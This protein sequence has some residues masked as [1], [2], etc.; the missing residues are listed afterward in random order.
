M[1]ES[2][3]RKVNVRA[4][5]VFTLGVSFLFYK[6]LVEVSPSVMTGKLMHFFHIDAVALGNIAASYY[7]IYFIMQLPMGILLDRFG[8]RRVMTISIFLCALG[9]LVFAYS[10]TFLM[11]CGGRFLTGLGA[12]VAAIGTLKLIT[13]WFNRK[14]FAFMTGL[15]MSIGMLGAV[16]GE[17]PLSVAID[18]FNW[19]QTLIFLACI[20]FVLMI[21]FWLVVKDRAPLRKLIDNIKRPPL[22]QS[23]K[24]VL[25]KPQTWWL[26][27]YS[28]LAFAPITAF[29][30]LWGV[31]FLEKAYKLS[32][33]QAAFSASL[34]FIGFAIGAPIFGYL[35]EKHGKRKPL[36]SL[37]TVLAF[38]FLLIIVFGTVHSVLLLQILL[39]GFGIG[40]AGFL[41]CFTMVREINPL[42][43]AGTVM[44][45]MN[46]F[47]AAMSAVT[48]PLIGYILDY[49]HVGSSINNFSIHDY[50]IAISTLLVYLLLSILLLFTLKETHC[51][52]LT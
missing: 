47:G 11:A 52:Q 29:G 1:N 19:S 15:M 12:S 23:L 10:Q 39:I 27:L 45:F 42:I 38:M 17:A 33:T 6:Y 31:P 2:Q 40:L 30:G 8:P 5:F 35:S 21:S 48:D 13:L 25:S 14:H 3:Q 51:Q 49:K 4:L 32:D 28:G 46:A 36:M 9:T 22:W 37:G 24:I 20:G 18:K 41:L 26:S 16:F 34:I 44:G 50:Q 43:L 7:Y